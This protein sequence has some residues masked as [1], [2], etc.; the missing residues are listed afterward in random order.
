MTKRNV[1]RTG[2]RSAG[3]AIRNTRRHRGHLNHTAPTLST[4][5]VLIGSVLSGGAQANPSGGTV[6]G[7]SASI[8]HGADT[9]NINQ[10][11]N[12]AII[13]WAKFGI[14]PG[15]TV[16][17]RQPG[18]QSVT[19]NRVIGSDPSAI[20]GALTANG[21]VMLVNPNGVVFGKGARI[22]VGGLI[23]TTANIR[24]DDFMAGRYRFD[25]PSNKLN[26]QVINEGHITIKDSGLAALVAPSVRNT[27]VIQA[28]L[29]KVAL[30]GAN[31]F[32][33]DFQGDG[34]L[35]FDAD[36]VVNQLPGDASGKPVALVENSGAI[37][38]DGGTVLLT[39]SAV[40]NVV[41]NVI[42][43]TGIIS[44]TSVGSRNGKIVLSGGQAGTVTASGTLNASGAGAG[45]Q[46]GKIVVTGERVAVAGNA[47]LDV[48]GAAGGGEIALGSLGVAPDNGA[49][50]FSGK[51]SSVAVAAGARLKADAL[52]QGKGGTVTLW[53]E[54]ATTHAGA[55][56]AR[57]GQQGGDGGFAEV[58]SKNNIGL[59]GSADL[60]APKGKT[61][62][63]LIDPTTLT[64]VDAES[65]TD[66]NT[67]ARGWLE[68]VAADANIRLE[69]TGLITVEAMAGNLIN[70]KTEDGHSFTM[71]STQFGGIK[72]ND[73]DTVIQ[74]AGGDITL[75]ALGSGSLQN[76]G[77]LRSQ[78]GDITLFAAGNIALGNDV[79][80]GAGAVTVQTTSGAITN[81]DNSHFVRG[82]SIKL[83]TG[84][85]G[86]GASNGTALRVA[87]SKLSIDARGDINLSNSLALSTLDLKLGHSSGSVSSTKYA[88]SLAGSNALSITDGA[89][90][91]VNASINGADLSI[92][93]DRAIAIGTIT[94]GSNTGSVRL[95]SRGAAVDAK[96]TISGGSITSGRIALDA[97]KTNGS[98]GASGR[99]ISTDTKHLSLASAGDVYVNNSAVLQSLSLRALHSNSTATPSNTY[100]IVSAAT[101]L[102]FS[103]SDSNDSSGLTLTDIRTGED[104][105]LSIET[106]RA[107]TVGNLET[108][109]GGSIKLQTSGTLYGTSTSAG[110]ADIVTGDLTLN[111]AA[112]QGRY[113]NY[114]SIPL[115]TSVDTLS[116]NI[117]SNL[118]LSNNKDL[119]LLDNRAG[120]SA[121]VE[122]S[123]GSLLQGAGGQ[124]VASSLKLV[125]RDSIGEDNNAL[126]TAVSTLTTETGQ[127]LHLDNERDLSGLYIT[128]NHSGPSNTGTNVLRVSADG[129]GFD[130]TDT[131]DGGRYNIATLTDETGI[132]FSFSGDRSL[133]V[134]V[135]DSGDGG[136]VALY[137]NSPA[138]NPAH[139]ITIDGQN[140]HITGN[141]VTLAATG[142]IGA[143]SGTMQTTAR[144]LTL[145]TGGNI[146]VDNHA[147]LSSLTIT[148]TNASGLD[149]YQVT[150]DALTFNVTTGEDGPTYVNEVADTTGLDFNLTTQR[151]QE[152]GIIQTQSHGTVSLTSDGS[153]LGSEHNDQRITANNTTLRTQ[154]GGNIGETGRDIRVTSPNLALHSTGSVSVDSDTH[155]DSLTIDRYGSGITERTYAISSPTVGEERL[156]FDIRDTGEDVYLDNV[157]DATGLD[158]TFISNRDITVGAL[159]M[160]DGDAGLVA[161]SSNI[162][163]DNDANT[164]IKASGLT[165]TAGKAVGADG[166]AIDAQVDRLSTTAD[167]GGAFLILDGAATLG[168]TRVS[169]NSEIT[170]K[171]SGDIALGSVEMNGY[172]LSVDNQGG[173]IL[174]GTISEAHTLNLIAAGSIGNHSA[175]STYANGNGT[176]TL[177]T[178][179]AR[180]A[181]GADGSIAINE[182]YGLAVVAVAGESDISLK[183]GTGNLTVGTVD[184]GDGSVTLSSGQ[185][186]IVAATGNKITGKES[187][188][189]TAK[190]GSGRGIGTSGTRL[191]VDTSSLTIATPGDFYITNAA[192]LTDLT[193]LRQSSLTGGSGGTMSLI[194][195]TGFTF[196]ATDNGA[197]TQLTDISDTT[198]LNFKYQ[199][200]DEIKVGKINVTSDG[201]VTLST[202]PW[203]SGHSGSITGISGSLITAG[204]LSANASS[205]FTGS[206]HIVLNT[207]V[208]SIDA[209]TD[210][211]GNITL[212]Q[213]GTLNLDSLFANGALSV[214]AT[215]GDLLVGGA[216]R[217]G[218]G[219][220]I[221]LTSQTGSI[222]DNGGIIYGSSSVYNAGIPTYG[223]VTLMAA[224][225]IGTGLDA[226]QLSTSNNAVSA[227]V[228]GDGS[229]YLDHA[230]NLNG[231]LTTSVKNGATHVASASGIV[232]TSM[233]ST[234]DSDGNDITVQSTNGDIT[235]AGAIAAGKNH[236]KVMLTANNG[237]IIAANGNAKVSANGIDLTGNSIGGAGSRLG[238]TGQNITAD[239]RSGAIYLKALADSTYTD[240]SGYG[241]IDI[242]AQGKLNLVQVNSHHGNVNV[243]NTGADSGLTLGEI[244]AGSGQVKL[245]TSGAMVDDGENDSRII[246]SVVDLTA[247][248]GIGDSSHA[249]QTTTANLSATTTGTGDIYLDDDRSNG[250]TLS[251]VSAKNGSIDIKTAGDTVA[252]SLESA[253]DHADNGITI[254]AGGGLT[255]GTVN[256]QGLGNVDLAAAGA[257]TGGVSSL[258]TANTLAVS[259]GNGIGTVTNP[260]NAQG[261]PLY[262]K[263]KSMDRLASSAK[264]SLIS[265]SNLGTDKLTLNKDVIALGEGGSAYISTAGDL[266]ISSGIS[267]VDGHLWLRSDGTL[268]IAETG[269][270]TAGMLSLTGI[271]DIVS[272]GEDSARELTINAGALNFN[273]GSKG[274]HTTLH[275]NT[276]SL[277]ARLTGAQKANLTIAHDAETLNATLLTHNGDITVE[278]TGLL[279]AL[280][281]ESDTDGHTISLASSESDIQVGKINA[282]DTGKVIL[283]AKNGALVTTD[284]SVLAAN[285]LDLLSLAGIGSA[286]D[287]FSTTARLVSAKVTGNDGGIYLEGTGEPGLVLG[288]ITTANGDIDITATHALLSGAGLSAGHGG[289]VTLNSDTSSVYVDH[290]LNLQDGGNLAI[291]A[292][293]SVYVAGDIE[294]TRSE[295]GE[296]IGGANLDIAATEIN[297][298]GSV[299]TDGAQDYHAASTLLL[300]SLT[301]GES[302]VFD[303]DVSLD[304]DCTCL[305]GSVASYDER[306]ITSAGGD[307]TIAGALDGGAAAARLTADK[308][309]ATIS[310]DA[311][312]LY[313]LEVAA[314]NI[315][316]ASVTTEAGQYYEGHTTLAGDYS[317]GEDGGFGV[318]G[319]TTLAG[320]TRVSAYNAIGFSG[321]VKGQYDLAVIEESGAGIIAFADTIGSADARLGTLTTSA[322]GTY[323]GGTVHADAV[324]ASGNVAVAGGR[325]DTTG[326]QTYHGQLHVHGDTTLAGTDITLKQGA[327][328]ADLT[329]TFGRVAEETG[330]APSFGIDGNAAITGNIGDEDSAF[331][332]FSISGATA[333]HG[334]HVYTT[335]DQRYGGAV[336]LDGNQS[337]TTTT[338]DI[339]FGGAISGRSNL[340][341]ASASGDVTFSGDVGAQ[342]PA[343]GPF[344][345]IPDPRL[346]DLVVTTAGTTTID[347]KVYAQNVNVNTVDGKGDVVIGGGLINT[348]DSGVQ[349]YQ[350]HVSLANDTVL[351]G[352][353]V[354]LE[355]GVDGM[356]SIDAPALVLNATAALGTVGA[357]HALASLDATGSTTLVGRGINTTGA[358]VYA[359]RL[360][361]NADQSLRSDYGNITFNTSIGAGRGLPVQKLAVR[362]NTG[363]V[364]FDSPVIRDVDL[365]ISSNTGDITFKRTISAG[366]TGE[367]ISYAAAISAN[368]SGIT[369]FD[370]AVYAASL[371][372]GPGK[373]LLNTGTINTTGEQ[374]YGG[375]VALAG[376]TALNGSH[377]TFA[378]GADSAMEGGKHAALTING[379]AS[380]AGDIGAGQALASLS[381]YGTS[382]L[383]KGAIAT[384]GEQIYAGAATLTGNQH[385]SSSSGD[386]M[387]Y[388]TVTGGHDLAVRADTGAALFDGAIGG[389][390][391]DRLGGLTLAAAEGTT[392]N[393]A[394]HARSLR[395]DGAVL[396]AGGR[397]ETTD[398][399]TYNGEA[400]IQ[401]D[402]TLAGTNVMLKQGATMGAPMPAYTRMPIAPPSSASLT[403]AG[404]AD[405]TGDVGTVDHAFTTFSVSGTTALRDGDVYTTG[406]QAYGSHVV[407]GNDTTLNGSQIT[408]A[409]GADSAMSKGK[410]AALT[411]NGDASLAGDIGARSALASLTVKGASI[412]GKG[413]I[414][415]VG[416]QA[417]AGA[418][419]LTGSQSL[420]S[421]QGGIDFADT[422]GSASRANLSLSAGDSINVQG[423]TAGL[424]ELTLSA[425]N[426]IVFNDALSA[427]RIQQLESAASAYRGPVTALGETGM[428]MTGG[429]FVFGDDLNASTGAITLNNGATGSVKFAKDATVHAAS[430]FTQN[431]GGTLQLPASLQVDRGP[432]SITALA[433]LPSGLASIKT[434]G[435]ITIA[436]LYGPDTRLTMSSGSGAQVVGLNNGDARYKINVAELIVPHAGS[437]NMYGTVGGYT[438]A[439][440]AQHISSELVGPPYYIN[441]TP[442]GPVTSETVNRITAITAPETI[443]PSTPG[444]D[445]LFRGTV[446]P[447]GVVPDALAP[448]ADPQVLTV[449]QVDFTLLSDTASS[450]PSTPSDGAADEQPDNENSN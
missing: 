158:F 107:L 433:S 137:A 302:I 379:N 184:A 209:T 332:D 47:L 264:N 46:G 199:S 228:S 246:A 265:I 142:S 198:G 194:G 360:F 404:N 123:G 7:G 53:S 190:Y 401:R 255:V 382:T 92:D 1:A 223:D 203:S 317:A 171:G 314:Q 367:D 389:S 261:M 311:S 164:Q 120:Y 362:T 266:D 290:D 168:Y 377:I 113:G 116:S 385:L 393:G 79:D 103:V 407:L 408:F 220:R 28:R 62:L 276:G 299:R 277:D 219:K 263:V 67:V 320:N 410:H 333:L 238:A 243:A 357:T 329:A 63:L 36:S 365:A 402:T 98:I 204:H 90:Q 293:T 430:G 189:L 59:T 305:L 416:N 72:F 166:N 122:T 307:I 449:A 119:T 163:G 441:G 368:T 29:G 101:G 234:T 315:S 318:Y 301:A 396:L 156:V 100:S 388:D 253:T 334:N 284:A 392:F 180:A 88:F 48:S 12:K 227:T 342:T 69:A 257:I 370:G 258:V 35:S 99:A 409:R 15:E 339:A 384:V 421:L 207:K 316:L 395:A 347:G 213:D 130:I 415:T 378:A 232:L 115:Y 206:S 174:S 191:N 153:I 267:Q 418:A 403:I 215:S 426:T 326:T 324:S 247:G 118:W 319:T 269:I 205:N 448:Y 422:L 51:S 58:S 256:A 271:D 110:D 14:K 181:N 245:S 152:I 363:N 446:T 96:P 308:G 133:H 224:K 167:N 177:Q 432:I 260:Q 132:N 83:S 218:S 259:A 350:G 108:G 372:T 394:V 387:F 50:A 399:Q 102:T 244:D 440:A 287:R 81:A 125:A 61:G 289:S 162:N 193:I 211:G 328:V 78:G 160:G 355:G 336:T 121:T 13:N 128:A 26:A 135:I 200:V 105:D 149:V 272:T 406:V 80:A 144:H 312:G 374:T 10:S 233:T 335:G 297:L 114:P 126:Q 147:D 41:D 337:M 175:I 176:T 310:G 182:S 231:G 150:S 242:E 322:A 274:G 229:L 424:G 438:G 24:D 390:G 331:A 139:D 32:T 202:N 221:A 216:L 405:I 340:T 195:P 303:G 292:E 222:L 196:S 327:V 19:L 237:R 27:G 76:I 306:Q 381:V 4:L 186:N 6:V 93:T 366:T 375:Q 298:L 364:V 279:N 49:A 330:T 38:A 444:A 86:I 30:A 278:T 157:T 138:A 313:S 22:D 358:Q 66:V 344:S 75:R 52:L 94:T 346:G 235:V 42:N 376:D 348:G 21:T 97:T 89:S 241:I 437:A 351:T 2:K 250:I 212:T 140:A 188:S 270:D 254:D 427:Y 439:P 304:A 296:D 343:E 349:E 56:S 111:A 445:S 148:S 187:I 201:S 373:V 65:S 161:H 214:T 70:L 356:E 159:D 145:T 16:N 173:S 295:G 230:G 25:Q 73:A 64:I 11:S 300:S 283:H 226:L 412:L 169:G 104:L 249:L 179:T 40:K 172:D 20:H 17:F 240:L 325:V 398:T 210:N 291:N 109:S 420:H 134:G 262:V 60:R 434:D 252:A 436:G 106:D 44:A 141:S 400:W 282:R 8:Q 225:G 143:D 154:S 341:L 411:I 33:L 55:I 129:L 369:T 37:H 268:T 285:E 112:V 391:T 431:G 127:D 136:S 192:D 87:T 84:T 178:V 43:T 170:N 275:T 185:G 74:T 34:L 435:A 5:A 9:V 85:G 57:G 165:L 280:S 273:S 31:S 39:A 197:I 183:A 131:G 417:Y 354:K 429:S 281:A 251:D 414:S 428:A 309:D 383:G 217:V 443:V 423:E 442:W 146:Y 155:I 124:Y 95:T 323:F 91:T 371:D 353:Q 361:I 23:A 208:D 380:L 359:Q 45:Q 345:R 413:S 117:G 18:S 419:T 286:E 151:S 82:D 321:K 71:E 386:I 352:L 68:D 397:V 338:G 77:G 447:E 248:T 288:Q 425:R 450:N 294:L 239:A 3:M 236:G 54:S